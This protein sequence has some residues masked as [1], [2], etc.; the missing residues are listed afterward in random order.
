LVLPEL[1]ASIPW[2]EI[3]DVDVV[4]PQRPG[5]ELPASPL[6]ILTLTPTGRELIRNRQLSN[7]PHAKRI[8]P[9]PDV[10]VKLNFLS[11]GPRME[12]AHDFAAE[13]RR[14]VAAAHGLP[15]DRPPLPALDAP[16]E[17]R[18]MSRTGPSARVYIHDL[19][20]TGT[21]ISGGSLYWAAN[22]FRYTGGDTMC[23]H[24]GTALD[25]SVRWEDTGESLSR[26]R[27]RMWR[28]TP[29][30]I[31]LL[32]FVVLPGVFGVASLA[33]FPMAPNIPPAV[34]K[35]LGF[36]IGFLAGNL[37]NWLTP[38]ASLIPALAGITYHKYR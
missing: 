30:L 31:K 8:S 25:K 9:R 11:F 12:T 21:V 5:Q 35:P 36:G 38:L 13:L 28:Q 37:L 24:C 32:Q 14:R 23:A 34:V 7:S 1:D 3:N 6:L 4:H 10:C 19:C 29:L 18:D 16:L 33:L 15:D 26:F 22:P 27:C 17:L 20:G 2:T